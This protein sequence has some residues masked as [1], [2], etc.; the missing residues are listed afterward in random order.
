MMSSIPHIISLRVLEN[1]KCPI[2]IRI[3]ALESHLGFFPSISSN[4][5]S[6]NSHH[7]CD[8]MLLTIFQGHIITY[9]EDE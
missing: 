2:F 1:V 5:N 3:Y 9:Y 7:Y 8:Y 4:H 6:S